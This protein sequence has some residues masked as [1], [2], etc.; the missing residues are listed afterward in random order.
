MLASALGKNPPLGIIVTPSSIN[1]TDPTCPLT[2]QTISGGA[3][4]GEPS[5]SYAWDWQVGGGGLVINS[6]SSQTTTVTVT[7]NSGSRSGTLRCTVTDQVP[8]NAAD[9]CSVVMECGLA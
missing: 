5:Y 7:G 3:F 4:G 1:E 8:D 9:T 2:S 6:P